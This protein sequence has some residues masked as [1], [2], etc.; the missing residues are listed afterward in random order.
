MLFLL[1]LG[2]KLFDLLVSLRDLLGEILS[3]CPECL[4]LSWVK[5]VTAQLLV[6]LFE[7]KG[8]INFSSLIFCRNVACLG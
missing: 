8:L 4:E 5:Y 1:K 7:L 6:C 2:L 3:A